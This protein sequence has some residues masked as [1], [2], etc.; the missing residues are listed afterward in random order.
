MMSPVT[1]SNC[2][3]SLQSKWGIPR[4]HINQE[5]Y[6]SPCSHCRYVSNEIKKY[7]FCTW[8]CLCAW[9]RKQNPVHKKHA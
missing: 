2:Q 4:W 6:S 9:V 8:K 3:G 5:I 1:C 7:Y